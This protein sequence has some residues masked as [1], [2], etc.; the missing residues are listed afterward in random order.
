MKTLPLALAFFLAGTASAA[1]IVVDVQGGGDY[2]QIQPAVNAAQ[3]GDTILIKHLPPNYLYGPFTINDKSLT[4]VAEKNA[5]VETY[6]QDILLPWVYNEIKNLN[7]T[8]AVTIRGIEGSFKLSDCQGSVRFEDC[9]TFGKPGWADGEWGY[10]ADAI[11]GLLIS[12]CSK[13]SFVHA[14]IAGADGGWATGPW[15]N[16]CTDPAPGLIA[17]GATVALYHCTVTGGHGHLGCPDAPP[18]QQ[19]GSTILA[20]DATNIGLRDLT[21]SSPLR[22]G[23]QGQIRIDC[24]QGDY[25]LLLL[26]LH[27]GF[28]HF[29]G[30][31]G[32]LLLDAPFSGVF[33]LGTLPAPG[34]SIPVA[35]NDIPSIGVAAF[36][37]PFQV[38]YITPQGT[39]IVGPLTVMTLL[40]P[41]F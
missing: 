26:S 12:S 6:H 38:G 36:D 9:A 21:G 35:F 18:I 24:E 13:V 41:Q 17:G 16:I 3:D 34:L 2:T 31:T 33:L 8:R 30:V 19:T 7:S 25:V 23:E 20:Y 29:P 1:V 37:V 39:G 14:T 4:L 28:L 22:R 27:P 5:Y 15:Y 10:G 32:T 40:D 11:P